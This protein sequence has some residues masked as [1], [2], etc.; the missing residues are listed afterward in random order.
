MKIGPFE[1]FPLYGTS[2]GTLNSTT[3]AV[4]FVHCVIL[5]T[6]N[7]FVVVVSCYVDLD[8]SY[9]QVISCNVV[10]GVCLFSHISMY[11]YCACCCV[12][13]PNWFGNF[14]AKVQD[15]SLTRRHS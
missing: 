7:C 1:N 4:F 9:G 13:H 6:E 11:V 5:C 10:L 14:T 8:N 15:Y 12:N 3:I 2:C